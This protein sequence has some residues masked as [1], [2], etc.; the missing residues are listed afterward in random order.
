VLQLKDLRA[1]SVGERVKGWDGGIR[2]KLEHCWH[3]CRLKGSK[4]GKSRR[5]WRL[6]AGVGRAGGD[7][8]RRTRERIA[9]GWRGAKCFAG[10]GEN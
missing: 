6:G 8:I 4:V 5:K 10:N 7:G 1:R 9:W 2:K 3:L